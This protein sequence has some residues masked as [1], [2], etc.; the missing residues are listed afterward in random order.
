MLAD[1]YSNHIISFI[2]ARPEFF[3]DVTIRWLDHYKIKYHNISLVEN[4]LVECQKLGVDI[5]ID[6][7]P[8]YAEEFVASSRPYI[9]F[10][11]PYNR[12]IDHELVYRAKSWLEIKNYLERPELNKE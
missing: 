8:H 10:D 2:T 7:A 5:L 6:D 4:K 1:L 11:Q 12:H 9:L 3:R